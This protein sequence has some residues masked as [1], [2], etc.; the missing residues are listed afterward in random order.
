MPMPIVMM[1]QHR[2]WHPDHDRSLDSAIARVDVV[3]KKTAGAERVPA[4]LGPVLRT[5][6]TGAAEVM[7]AASSAL[8]F[9]VWSRN[10]RIDPLDRLGQ[11]SGLAS[12]QLRFAAV[13]VCVLAVALIGCRTQWWEQVQRLACAAVAGLATG[14][15]GGGVV[16]ALLGTSLPL[17]GDLGDAHVLATWADM[18]RTGAELPA[19][20]PPLFIH[21]LALWAEVSGTSSIEALKPLALVTTSLFGPA[22]YLAWRTLLPPV[23]ALGVG[24]GAAIPLIEP[25]KPYANLVLV[26]L[27]PVTVLFL[28]FL[29]AGAGQSGYPRIV[30]AG[31]AFGVVLAV[32]FLTYS[33]WYVWSAPGVLAAVSLH[34]PWRTGR[35]RGFVLLATSAAVFCVISARHLVGLLLGSGDMKDA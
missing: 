28:R 21:V 17:F 26:V 3:V 1:S 29:R 35:L 9:L 14:L 33:G 25:Y 13:G 22:A 8:L 23:W 15:V 24:L 6:I 31:A 4:V 18:A 32:L 20:Y 7:V 16:L 10:I 5:V 12:L 30:L 19:T 27:V 11:V 2:L 34:F